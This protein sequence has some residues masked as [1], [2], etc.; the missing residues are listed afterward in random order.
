MSTVIGVFNNRNQAEKAIDEIKNA[1][2]SEEEI[3][4]V[5]KEEVVN[6]ANGNENEENSYLNQDLTTGASTGGALGGLAGIL[7]GAGALAIPGVGPV[8]AAGPIAAGLTGVA[9]GGLAGSLVD[10]GIP[11]ERGDY[12]ENEVRKGSILATVESDQDKVEEVASFMRR[13]GARDVETH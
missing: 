5:A 11:Q 1:G 12:Y 6:G 4:I 9:T 2:I 13:N 3:S 8:L 10:L 7:A